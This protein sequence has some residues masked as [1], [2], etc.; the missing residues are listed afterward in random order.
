MFCLQRLEE[1]LGLELQ[2]WA[3]LHWRAASALN[4]GTI[5]PDFPEMMFKK[6]FGVVNI[7]IFFPE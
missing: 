1:G 4:Y 6:S 2:D 3:G 7:S 5:L